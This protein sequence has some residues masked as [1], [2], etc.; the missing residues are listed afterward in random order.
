MAD[1]DDTKLSRLGT[2]L[3]WIYPADP[4]NPLVGLIAPLFREAESDDIVA[5]GEPAPAKRVPLTRPAR[6]RSR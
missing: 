2:R 5:D 4:A 3:E 6:R 1:D